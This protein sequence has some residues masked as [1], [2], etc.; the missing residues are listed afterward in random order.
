MPIP[1]PGNDEDERAFMD[2]CMGDDAMQE[3]DP[4][5]RAGVCSTAYAKRAQKSAREVAVWREAD[6]AGE[7]RLL[8]GV[9]YAPNDVDAHGDFAD[10]ETIEEAAHGF[11][12]SRLVG[13]QHEREAPARIVESFIAPA[14]MTIGGRSV[15]RGSWVV[16]IKV[17]DDELWGRVKAGEFGGLSLGGYAVR[18]E[19]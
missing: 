1:T 4:D 8:Y 17:D 12:D 14:D 2:R 7:K 9:V 6:A 5:Q 13:I 19:V 18:E 3:Y 11:M 10:A 16:A 15:T